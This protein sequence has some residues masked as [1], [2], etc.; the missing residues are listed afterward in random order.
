MGAK[1]HYNG[2]AAPASVTALEVVPASSPGPDPQFIA[3]VERIR[4]T[5]DRAF[6]YLS[7]S[8]WLVLVAGQQM[9]ELKEIIDYGDF[10]FARQKYFPKIGERAARNWQ[11]AAAGILREVGA[12]PAI[13]I[14]VSVI[15]LSSEKDL[16]AEALEYR[17][18]WIDCAA[19]KTLAECAASGMALSVTR[20]WNGRTKGGT[21]AFDERKDYSKH[22][23]QHMVQIAEH[24]SHYDSFSAMQKNEVQRLFRAAIMGRDFV[25]NRTFNGRDCAFPAD[26]SGSERRRAMWPKDLCEFVLDALKER[27]KSERET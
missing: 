11:Q 3:L 6:I 18:K 12:P 26:F 19:D 22:I 17:N 7:E 20:A 5:I 23:M 25:L 24:F 1:K 21:T 9:N 16:S 15:L 14:P 8:L 27:L 13:G 2:L 10:E 4:T